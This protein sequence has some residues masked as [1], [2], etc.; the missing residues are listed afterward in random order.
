MTT[1][2]TLQLKGI[3]FR[4]IEEMLPRPLDTDE[5]DICLAM[6]L[7]GEDPAMVPRR[8]MV[9]LMPSWRFLD[10]MAGV[11][12]QTEFTGEVV[13]V[14]DHEYRIGD[15][16]MRGNLTGQDMVMLYRPANYHEMIKKMSGLT[17]PDLDELSLAQ[18]VA[19]R[20]CVRPLVWG[21]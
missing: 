3:H 19:L 4:Q 9:R 17:T 8:K 21:S 16:T 5:M 6:L 7:H 13:K 15:I 10:Y 14:A 1:T 2:E 20:G 18:Y 12:A 11:Y